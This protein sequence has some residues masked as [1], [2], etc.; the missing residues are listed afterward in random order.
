MQGSLC[1]EQEGCQ[2]GVCELNT[3]IP[4]GTNHRQECEWRTQLLVVGTLQKTNKEESRKVKTLFSE[5]KFVKKQ[6]LYLQLSIMKFQTQ[7][8]C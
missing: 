8:S 6:D 5:T 3:G 1:K 7:L 2:G 4:T